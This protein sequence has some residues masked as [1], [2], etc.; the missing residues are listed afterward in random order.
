MALFT[1]TCCQ[2][3]KGTEEF[4]Y[5]DKE[6]GRRSRVCKGCEN[7]RRR[8][9]AKKTKYGDRIL[10]VSCTHFPFDQSDFLEWIY[11]KWKE[12]NC[13]QFIHLGDLYDVAGCN[14]FFRDPHM[15]SIDEEF[16]RARVQCQRLFTLF[17]NAHYIVGNHCARISRAFIESGLPELLMPDPRQAFGIPDGWEIHKDHIEMGDKLFVHGDNKPSDAL[18]FAKMVGK[19]VVMGDKHTKLKV[20]H[21][22]NDYNTL[23][24]VNVGCGIS[25]ERKAFDYTKKHISKPIVGCAVIINDTPHVFNMPLD[26]NGRWT[27]K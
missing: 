14:R 16:D 2:A 26:E 25:R 19:K 4:L 12:F 6:K 10:V 24:A 20:E 18:G 23:W 27:G 9:K 5:K 17:P 15:P 21:I 11:S 13:N 3:I 7:A 8:Q 1:C 22:N